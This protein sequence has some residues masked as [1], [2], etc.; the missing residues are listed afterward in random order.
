MIAG[1]I[2]A[3]RQFPA[4]ETITASDPET[5]SYVVALMNADLAPVRNLLVKQKLRSGAASKRES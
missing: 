3:L 1:S 4:D 5:S 2:V